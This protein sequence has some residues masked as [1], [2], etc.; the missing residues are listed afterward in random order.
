AGAFPTWLSPTQVQIITVSDNNNDYAK[1]V[2]AKLQ[3]KGIRVETD[4][5]NESVGKKIRNAV[6]TKSPYVLVLGDK[7][8]ADGTVAVRARGSK[9]TITMNYIDFENEI[10]EKINSKALN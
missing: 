10:M 7:E 6:M 1:D 5:S 2:Q 8:M 3:A 4:L 9:D